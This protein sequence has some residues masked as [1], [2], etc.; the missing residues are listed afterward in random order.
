MQS[1]RQRRIMRYLWVVMGLLLSIS[2]LLARSLTPD[3]AEHE[4]IVDAIRL[5]TLTDTALQRDAL[6]ARAGLLPNYDPLARAAERLRITMAE[7]R[8]ADDPGFARRLDVLNSQIEE[9]ESLLEVF[10]SDNAL[11]Q[12]SLRYLTYTIAAPGRL[13]LAEASPATTSELG[14]LADA[15]LLFMHDPRPDTTRQVNAI[16]DRLAQ[17]PTD[18]AEI[19]QNLLLLVKHGRLIVATLPE[20]DATLT[21]LLV[22]PVEKS[23]RTLTGAYLEGYARTEAMARL[24][25]VLLWFSAAALVASLGYLFYRIWARAHAL[26]ERSRLLQ[27]RLDAQ[28]LLTEAST[29]VAM[30]RHRADLNAAINRTMGRLGE[31]CGIDRAYVVLVDANG[32]PAEISH[33]WFRSGVEPSPSHSDDLVSMRRAPTVIARIARHERIVIPPI[34]GHPLDSEKISLQRLGIAGWLCLPIFAGDRHI[35]LLGFEIVRSGT[36]WAKLDIALLETTGEIVANAIDRDRTETE[37][38]ELETRLR[39]SEKLEAIGTLASGIAHDFNSILSAILGYGDM[40]M[41]ALDPQS[42][43]RR[44]VQ[45]MVAAGGRAASLVDSILLFS[46]SSGRPLRPIRVQPIVE[47]AIEMLRAANPAGIAI[48]ARHNEGAAAATV[49][50]DATQLHQII[51]NLCTNAIQALNNTGTV[52]IALGVVDVAGELSLGSSSLHPGRYV[53]LAVTDTG[54]GMDAATMGRI[55]EPF[56]TTKPA[57][58]GTGLGLATVHG[59]VTDLNGRIDVQSRPGVGSAFNVYL[60]L[61]D[62]EEDVAPDYGQPATVQGRGEAVLLV[63]DDTPLVRLGEEMLAALGYEPIGFDS[64]RRALDAFLDDPMRFDIVLSDAVMPEM[65]GLMLAAEIHKVRPELPILLMTAHNAP[66]HG[67]ML[68]EAGVCTVLKKPVRSMDLATT[69]A[70]Q[71]AASALTLHPGM[72]PA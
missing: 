66:M 26:A 7:L 62:V 59:I 10:K 18:D 57:R 27:S 8:R 34:E 16:L 21:G 5:L 47:E 15:M 71:L 38:R 6:Q 4:R 30:A 9:R 61:T 28:G 3:R 48:R 45:E 64:S 63:D 37:R 68:R 60:P 69:I 25:Q 67:T 56:F 35:G 54:C 70:A 52:D 22:V 36:E 12:N 2:L 17:L 1:N 43:A 55:F 53:R 40:A 46:R 49:M 42:R 33:L 14:R 29:R 24:L 39:Q 44:H 11:L 19:A 20:V 41:L 23:A 58:Q 72:P 65:D 31:T 13:G 51:M 50:G 32:V